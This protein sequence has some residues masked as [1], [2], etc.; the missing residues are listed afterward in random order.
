MKNMTS[1]RP[2]AQAALLSALLN[3]CLPPD[4]RRHNVVCEHDDSQ[5]DHDAG[6]EAY[7]PDGLERLHGIDERN[8]GIVPLPALPETTK[9]EGDEEAQPAHDD[10]PETPVSQRVAV[11]LGLPH[12]RCDVIDTRDGEKGEAAEQ[13][14][15]S[16]AGNPIGLG[17]N[18]VDGAQAVH[19]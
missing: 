5:E 11:Q 15:V 8:R 13:G 4:Y 3:I 18:G 10:E 16:V 14:H 9:P 6:E 19:W 12:P 1:A 17:D 2:T 7:Q